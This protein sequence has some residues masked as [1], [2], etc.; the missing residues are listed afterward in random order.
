[1]R[2][3]SPPSITARNAT[4]DS[5]QPLSYT[6]T[7]TPACVG[8]RTR[9]RRHGLRMGLTMAERYERAAHPQRRIYDNDSKLDTDPACDLCNRPGGM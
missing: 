5:V 2:A 7:N 1:M 4:S 3:R 8:T 9:F 6:C